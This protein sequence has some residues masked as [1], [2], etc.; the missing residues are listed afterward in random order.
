[1]VVDERHRPPPRIIDRPGRFPG[2]TD[3]AVIRGTADD[4]GTLDPD[5]TAASPVRRF[6]PTRRGDVLGAPPAST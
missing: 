1:V 6:A 4:D 3:V 5:G 2:M